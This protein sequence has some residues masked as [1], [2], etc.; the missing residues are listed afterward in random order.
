MSAMSSRESSGSSGPVA[1]AR[2]GRIVEQFYCS[3]IDIRMYDRDDLVDDVAIIR[4]PRRH[5][6]A[7]AAP[8][9]LLDQRAVR[10]VPW[11]NTSRNAVSV[12][13]AGGCAASWRRAGR[14]HRRDQGRRGI[15]CSRSPPGACAGAEAAARRRR[16]SSRSRAT[17]CGGHDTEQ[18]VPQ[19][20]QSMFTCSAAASS[21]SAAGLG[22]FHL[23]RPVRSCASCR[24]II[25]RRFDSPTS[26]ISAVVCGRR[27]QLRLE[28]R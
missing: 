13:M 23:E 28:R 9:R 25:G 24:K 14:H 1:P 18:S 16:S 15:G 12:A 20:I 7:K 10:S 19:T 21:A 17:I 26:A 6:A 11:S 2:R 27:E 4:G 22:F 5:R 3:E 8:D